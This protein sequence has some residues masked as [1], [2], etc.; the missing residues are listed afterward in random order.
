MEPT[1]AAGPVKEDEASTDERAAAAPL[2]GAPGRVLALQRAIGNRALMKLL[3]ETDPRLTYTKAAEAEGTGLDAQKLPWA[4]PGKQE[5]GWNSEEIL[6]KLTQVDESG[7]TFT[8][9]VRCGANSVLAVAITRGPLATEAWARGIMLNALAQSEDKALPS[10]R[11][12]TGKDVYLLIWPAIRAVGNGTATY[13]DLSLIAHY[14]KVVMSEK[15]SSSTT[16][17]EVAAMAAILGGMRESGEPIQDKEQFSMFARDLKRGNSYILLVGTNVLAPGV[18]SRNLGQVNH[19]VVLGKDA[20][21]K[22]FL[23]DPYP[24]V[25]AQLLRSSDPNF[26]TL[27]ET[28]DGRWKASYIFVRPKTF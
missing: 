22:V 2:V 28:A 26:W 3:R 7:V 6:S 10:D 8:D 1:R 20:N 24:R 25:G 5:G 21:G 11:R 27:F 23:Y 9:P 17:H 16:G 14:A 18:M 15:A 4:T 13:G 12:T 19:Y